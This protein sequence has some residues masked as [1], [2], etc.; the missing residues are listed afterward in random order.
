MTS[1]SLRAPPRGYKPKPALV[2]AAL[3]Y[4]QQEWA[5]FAES[6]AIDAAIEL[7]PD[8]V[9]LPQTARKQTRAKPTKNIDLSQNVDSK[10][11]S[12]SRDP[13]DSKLDS[14]TKKLV[15]KEQI[16]LAKAQQR[17]IEKKRL[18]YRQFWL[19]QVKQP[20]EDTLLQG[21][22]GIQRLGPADVSAKNV[23]LPKTLWTDTVPHSEHSVKMAEVVHNDAFY[24]WCF[25]QSFS[26]QL[27]ICK[28][29]LVAFCE[30]FLADKVYSLTCDVFQSVL[31]LL[32]PSLS[33]LIEQQLVVIDADESQSNKIA[34]KLPIS[35]NKNV[36]AALRA[37]LLLLRA[38]FANVKLSP[39]TWWFLSVMAARYIDGAGK[40]YT[41]KDAVSVLASD[42]DDERQF[43]DTSWVTDEGVDKKDFFNSSVPARF[44]VLK[45]LVDKLLE[46]PLFRRLVDVA[47]EAHLRIVGEL[48][49]LEKEDRKLV[50]RIG[51]IQ[52]MV[53]GQTVDEGVSMEQLHAQL[54]Q[55]IT[56]RSLLTRLRELAELDLANKYTLQWSILG[57]D[58][59]SNDYYSV[60]FVHNCVIVHLKNSHSLGI[61]EGELEL[62][63]LICSMDVRGYREDT[64]RKELEV[65]KREETGSVN[66]LCH[67][68][69]D[70]K[71]QDRS[72]LMSN[73]S[74]DA[75]SFRSASVDC[76]F[77][78]QTLSTAERCTGLLLQTWLNGSPSVCSFD[79]TMG[80]KSGTI[81]LID[82]L[83]SVC[84]E[85]LEIHGEYFSA[86]PTIANASQDLESL[87]A[88]SLPELSELLLKLSDH[89]HYVPTH[90][91]YLWNDQSEKLAWT[92]IL[93][94][95]SERSQVLPDDLDEQAP[96]SSFGVPCQF[97]GRYFVS[98]IRLN[99]HT[100][101]WCKLRPEIVDTVSDNYKRSCME[102]VEKLALPNFPL[103]SAARL[104]NP[105]SVSEFSINGP[106]ACE[107][108]VKEYSLQTTLAA[109]RT[110]WCKG[111]QSLGGREADEVIEG[112]PFIC[113]HCNKEVA[114]AQGLTVHLSRWCPAKDYGPSMDL[115]S[116]FEE[117]PAG[118]ADH[119]PISKDINDGIEEKHKTCEVDSGE[120]DL[121]SAPISD[122]HPSYSGVSAAISWLSQALHA[123]KS[124]LSEK[125]KQSK[126]RK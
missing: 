60:P 86:S 114:T 43:L 51:A 9:P 61:Y 80:D 24:V 52:R 32:I 124:L 10:R 63:S 15:D 12:K 94:D 56:S 70:Y 35:G 105:S 92:R 11:A 121:I 79:C 126:R 20:L 117:T 2:F 42:E 34:S 75:E 29:S 73:T 103:L 3:P 109:H 47:G 82:H 93:N 57:Q 66:A 104:T 46:T 112:P 33:C 100:A 53:D 68:V 18:S 31:E 84:S 97:C 69:E 89:F 26:S 125:I 116:G 30:S 119:I 108:C 14:R 16:A 71:S 1:L 37:E 81:D 87:S 90:D 5:C 96:G 106:F 39:S 83:R 74:F 102:R 27:R 72:Q 59:F 13:S 17:E 123:L 36:V 67:D 7:F 8:E 78:I 40:I 23:Y 50:Q 49:N 99:M 110:R 19:G 64:L 41:R 62:D 113:R 95:L 115:V 107:A 76:D 77:L 25:L 48:S 111:P 21:K 45:A 4:R 85:L 65:V 98:N 122:C 120:E 44:R 55:D 6:I 38:I 28:F 54:A 58:R 91:L 22:V 101:R 118:D 88:D